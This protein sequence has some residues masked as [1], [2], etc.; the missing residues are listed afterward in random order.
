M[1]STS[2]RVVSIALTGDVTTATLT[3]A[4]TTNTSSPAQTDLVTL[5]SGNNFIPFPT[6]G[7]SPAGVTITPPAGN[8]NSIT[9]KGTTADTGLSL[10]LTDPTSLGLGSTTGTLVLT[11]SSTISGV[12]LD[13]S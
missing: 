12:R 2:R 13:W 9:L 10:H 6:G 11:A 1:A 5:A 8:T 7:S 4:A 3:R